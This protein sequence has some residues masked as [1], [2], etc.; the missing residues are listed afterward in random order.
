M[1]DMG[2]RQGYAKYTTSTKGITYKGMFI[3]GQYE[4]YGVMTTNDNTQAGSYCGE[5]R[6]SMRHGKGRLV[7]KHNMTVY[8]GSLQFIL[9]FFW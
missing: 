7:S 4:G 9:S 2:K 6:N 1:Y 3:Q 5:F 8:E